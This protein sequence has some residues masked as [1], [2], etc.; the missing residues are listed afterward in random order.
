M[1]SESAPAPLVDPMGRR[2]DYLRLAVTDRCNLRCS[3][4]MP[5]E[6]IHQ[7]SHDDIL[8]F[9]EMQR[10]A[11][12]LCELGV[13]RIRVT[14]GEPL[15]R[16]GLIPFLARLNEL[17]S[18]PELLLTTNG[19]LLRDRLPELYSAGVR[20]INLSIDSLDRETYKQI[21]R[22][23]HLDDVLP[24]LD[25]IPAAGFGL[26]VNVVILPSVN[27]HEI[28]DFAELIRD[29]DICIRFIEPMPFDGDG[30]KNATPFDGDRIVERLLTKFPFKLLETED[31]GVA[32]LYACEGWRGRVGV[33]RGHTRTF[34]GSCSRLRID[35]RGGLRTCLYG[36][37]E[38]DLRER[39][40]SGVSDADM[41][42]E[43]RN[44]VG[45]RQTDGFAAEK[46]RS[47]V[48]CES[49]SRIGG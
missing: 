38:L 26:K 1:H 47:G 9:E 39:I 27:D 3:Y 30:G 44:V 41:A 24:L 5:E 43:I 48:Q 23:D 31:G 11:A 17:P 12:L 18:R 16:K 32:D 15:A 36:P 46:A 49:M 34:C 4:C 33:I 14:G 42:D 37:A 8:S 19:I 45:R 21:T 28:P 7:V 29:R 2:L 25:S 40:R 10:C 35:T 6:G 13:N 20:R 22:R